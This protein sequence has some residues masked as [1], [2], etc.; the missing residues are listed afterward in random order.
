MRGG[1]GAAATKGGRGGGPEARVDECGGRQGGRERRAYAASSST[2]YR[3]LC[4]SLDIRS[5]M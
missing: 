2:D 3:V 5:T 4:G 1:G